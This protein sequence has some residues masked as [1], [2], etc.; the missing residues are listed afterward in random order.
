MSYIILLEL[1][2]LLFVYKSFHLLHIQNWLIIILEQTLKHTNY[3]QTITINSMYAY[4]IGKQRQLIT[5]YGPTSGLCTNAI[6]LHDFFT[7]QS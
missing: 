2:V 4:N 3:S 1:L 6:R 5:F 7:I